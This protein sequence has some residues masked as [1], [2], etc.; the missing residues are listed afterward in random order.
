LKLYSLAA[1]AGAGLL[2][3]PSQADA[4]IVYTAANIDVVYGYNLD[5]NGD[6]I[7]DFTF[8]LV[9]A[10]HTN[11][12]IVTLDVAGN[13][14][15]PPYKL[16]GYDAAA[17]PAGAPIGN[18]QQ[19]TSVTS[20]GGLFIAA[21]FGYGSSTGFWGPWKNANGRY[22]GLKFLINGQVHYGWARMSISNWGQAGG[23]AVLSGY[24]YETMP[25]KKITAGDE[26]PASS[27]D[28][29]PPAATA[30]SLALLARGAEGLD[31]WRRE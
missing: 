8:E 26:G 15:R 14:I 20:Y 29:A 19:F 2:A 18:S 21:T 3:F 31:A 1:A 22:L 10:D 24:A 27:A 30:Q 25:N 16:T 23:K 4:K 7:P 11:L 5:V 9:E 6:G 28:A 17:L 13:Q 12:L